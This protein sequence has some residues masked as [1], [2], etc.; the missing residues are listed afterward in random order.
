MQQDWNTYGKD[1]FTATFIVFGPEWADKTK[2]VEKEDQI[3]RQ[4]KLEEVYNKHPCTKTPVDVK[5][6]RVGCN[7]RGQLF[8]SIGEAVR[9]LGESETD[10]R[11]KLN[12]N[13]PGYTIIDK[14]V[15]YYVT[16]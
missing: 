15:T 9:I 13:Y 6:Y 14:V 4:Y 7:I 1:C 10:I 2:R 8:N 16:T 11:R 3:L 5:N 12:N